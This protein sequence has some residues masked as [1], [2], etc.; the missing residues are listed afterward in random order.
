[1][2]ESETERTPPSYYFT[3]ATYFASGGPIAFWRDRF[4]AANNIERY[5]K[6]R[7]ARDNA[8]RR[9]ILKSLA[10]E[11]A[12]FK[13]EF[14]PT[15]P[16]RNLI[17]SMPATAQQRRLALAVIILLSV[18]FALI[19]PF[20]RAQPGPANAFIPVVQTALCFADLITAVFL[21][22]QYSI[23][24][25]CA[26]LALASGYICS[27]LFA[28]LQT[29]DFPGAY[30]TNGL[31]SGG[32]S[33]AAWLFSLWHIAVP[34]AVML[35][36]LLKDS[37]ETVRLPL[38]F[39]LGRTIAVTVGC[40]LVVTAG[41]TWVVATEYLPSTF[42]DFTRMT[43]FRGEV[44]AERGCTPFAFRSYAEHPRSMACCDAPRVMALPCI[45]GLVSGRSFL[46]WRVCDPYLRADR[47]RHGPVCTAR[48]NDDAE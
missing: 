22:A 45:V 28:L 30:S 38:T 32:R 8:E 46:C 39:P 23:Q 19:M 37:D 36:A 20:A 47:Q 6:L 41:V 4:V 34:F 21:F 9:A 16:S 2:R 10:P 7:E 25:Q 31:L 42:F 13:L 40:V 29:L 24:P 18:V 17:A 27:G 1:M 48:R 35:Y 11:E 43:P 44:D 5:R 12:T 15:D 33:G 14:Q 3:R 26:L